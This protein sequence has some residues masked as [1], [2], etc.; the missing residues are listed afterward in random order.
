MAV[1]FA[2]YIRRR[3]PLSVYHI[4]AQKRTKVTMKRAISPGRVESF[5]R[6]WEPTGTARNFSRTPRAPLAL[7]RY[8]RRCI[9]PRQADKP[10]ATSSLINKYEL[11]LVCLSSSWPVVFVDVEKRRATEWRANSKPREGISR[12]S[13]VR[14]GTRQPSLSSSQEVI[15]PVF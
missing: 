14:N 15:A 1:L 2:P 11:S 9:F 12:H 13:F 7:T 3:R 6:H 10:C 5:P 4:V 8:A